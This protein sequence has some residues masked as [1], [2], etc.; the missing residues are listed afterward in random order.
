MKFAA[1][2]AVSAAS[3]F[4]VPALAQDNR[5]PSQDFAGPYISLGGGASLQGRDSG[6]TLIFAPDQAG[7]YG[8]QVTTVGTS[9]PFGSGF[10]TGCASGPAKAGCRNEKDG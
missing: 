7:S 2:L 10:G 9:D 5:D 1:L 6:E 3:I 4:A 8:D